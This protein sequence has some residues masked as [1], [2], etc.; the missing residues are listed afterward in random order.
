MKYRGFTTLEL[1]TVIAV[2]GIM[3]SI[4]FVSLTPQKTS[5]DLE[6]AARQFTTDIK[7]I[8]RSVLNGTTP[9]NKTAP[10]CGHGV[11]TADGDSQYRLFVVEKGDVSDCLGSY[12]RTLAGDGEDYRTQTFDPGVVIK[13]DADIF[14]QVPDAKVYVN[15][16]LSGSD[17]T[18]TFEKGGEHCDVSISSTGEITNDTCQ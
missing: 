9:S 7:A 4:L 13:T 14:F 8:Q 11:N 17:T 12:M 10:I 5:K 18:F 1:L 3:S 16:F 15:D 6:N 2:I